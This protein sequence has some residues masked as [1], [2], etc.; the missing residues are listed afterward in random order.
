MFCPNCFAENVTPTCSKCGYV[1]NPATQSADVLAPGVILNNRYKIGRCL[2]QGGF[3]VTYLA[4]DTFKDVLCC[5]KEYYPSQIVDRAS[6]N[7][8]TVHGED[9]RKRYENGRKDFIDEARVLFKLQ[10]CQNIVTVTDFFSEFNSAYIVMDYLDGMN[11]KRAVANLGGKVPYSNA[12]QVILTISKALIE[13]HRAGLLH[14]DISPENIFITKSGKITLIDFGAAR[15]RDAESMSVLIKPGYAPPEQYRKDGAQ[16]PWT[17]IYALASTF[18]YIISGQH[19]IPSRERLV[20][21]KMPPLKDVAPSVN[22]ELSRVIAKAMALDYRSRYQDVSSFME[23]VQRAVNAPSIAPKRNGNP[24]VRVLSGVAA[25]NVVE[26]NPNMEFHIGRIKN[27]VYEGSPIQ[28]SLII[29]SNLV[30]GAHCTV[31]YLPM[32]KEFVFVDHSSNGTYFNNS[33]RLCYGLE[34]KIPPK[35]ILYLAAPTCCKIELYL[36]GE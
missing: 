20:E 7:F 24:C 1:Y 4:Y 9:M 3:G 30:S 29:P 26:F 6:N 13:V 12:V 22:D 8:L 35:T 34:Y 36:S 18:Y 17:D 19:V 21:D 23:D 14:R 10:G 5:V 27:G 25:G 32:E 33:N 28:N 15:E 2:G 16:G 11:L 31:K